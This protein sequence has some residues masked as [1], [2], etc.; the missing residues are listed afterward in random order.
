MYEEQDTSKT[1]KKHQPK[2]VAGGQQV[3]NGQT[4]SDSVNT[5]QNKSRQNVLSPNTLSK[6]HLMM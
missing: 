1:L 3:R 6:I 2:T 4:I 5:A